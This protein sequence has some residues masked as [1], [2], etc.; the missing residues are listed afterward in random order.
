MWPERLSNIRDVRGRDEHLPSLLDSFIR[1][2][3]YNRR[4]AAKVTPKSLEYRW[5]WHLATDGPDNVKVVDGMVEFIEL[6]RWQSY[7]P[8]FTGDTSRITLNKPK[9]RDE[10][11]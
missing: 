4:D 2:K 10:P 5:G 3:I 8:F 9:R 7:P 11:I 1:F 6:G